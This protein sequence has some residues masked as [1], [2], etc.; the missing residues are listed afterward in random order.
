MKRA[1]GKDLPRARKEGLLIQELP[2]EFLIYDLS[3][4]KAHCLNKTAAL[5]W[6]RC[7]GKT[8]IAETTKFLRKQ[9]ESHVDAG[10]VLLA[11]DRLGKVG[12]IEEGSAPRDRV[13]RRDVLRRIGWAAA[14][15]LP[16]VTSVVAPTAASAGSCV[17]ES[18]CNP[19][20]CGHVCHATGSSECTKVCRPK[21]DRLE[22]CR[23]SSSGDWQC[24][25]LPAGSNPCP[26]P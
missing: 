2:E 19:S 26:C 24:V 14:V 21:S 6:K 17:P 12:L 15:T 20:T 10:V 13:S 25:G 22:N 8:S 18:S 11:L 3:T 1:I 16:L 4:A 5:V 9:L 23:S 7:D